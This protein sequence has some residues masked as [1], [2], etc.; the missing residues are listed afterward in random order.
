MRRPGSVLGL[1]AMLLRLRAR[2]HRAAL[3]LAG[4]ALAAGSVALRSP[5]AVTASPEARAWL[6]RP[7]DAGFADV[8]PA[9]AAT[10]RGWLAA[11]ARWTDGAAVRV[12]ALGLDGAPRGEAVRVSPEGSVA[13]GGRLARCGGRVGVAWQ[14]TAPGTRWPP[15]AW[16]AA[17][18]DDGAVTVPARRLG[19]G[20]DDQG[21]G[22]SLV[23]DGDGWAL[24]VDGFRAPSRVLRLGPD[25]ALRGA[26]V[27]LPAVPDAQG[28]E[29]IAAA[30]DLWL[31]AQPRYDR[32]R[33]RSALT[34]RWVSRDGRVVAQRETEWQPGA[35]GPFTWSVHGATAW[36]VQGQD[37]G[38][39]LRH[40]PWLLRVDGRAITLSPR[41]LGP[42]RS[43]DVPALSC[44]VEGCVAAWSEVVG[45]EAPRL[46]VQAL[47]RD[48][49]PRGPVRALGP[50]S[51]LLRH[52]GVAL[53]RTAD[54]NALRAVWVAPAGDGLRVVTVGITARG[55]PSDAPRWLSE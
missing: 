5:P 36:G 48:G 31:A 17:V 53:A 43:A 42:R 24:G 18:D 50:A 49:A 25:G 4:C 16:F 13:R 8:D 44:D 11:W 2:R 10:P 3:A 40:E 6:A 19:D 55:V 15:F 26:A 51:R 37:Q 41:A 21:Q 46:R 33:D 22:I 20:D 45:A 9:L 47:T 28:H 30:G 39:E 7:T 54:T 52:G 29:A 35:A 23:C 38:F 12:R 1:A 27:T 34:L 14:G 32:V